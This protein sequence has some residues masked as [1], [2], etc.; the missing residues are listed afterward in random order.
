MLVDLLTNHTVSHKQRS[1]R[2]EHR[3]RSGN[4]SLASAT[5]ATVAHSLII[6]R[7]W[8]WRVEC[9]C[10]ANDKF[11]LRPGSDL[12]WKTLLQFFKLVI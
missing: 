12:R 9:T 4:K 11:I 6:A 2:V 5:K 8:Q 7:Q 3:E 1:D 10:D